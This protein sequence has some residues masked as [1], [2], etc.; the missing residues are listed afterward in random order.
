MGNNSSTHPTHIILAKNG[1]KNS[2]LENSYLVENEPT[3][4]ITPFLYLGGMYFYGYLNVN[5]MSISD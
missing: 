3:L 1:A 2:E 5:Y 4:I